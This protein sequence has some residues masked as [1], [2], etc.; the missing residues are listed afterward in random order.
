[1]GKRIEI[2]PHEEIIRKLDEDA[3]L[4]NIL[5]LKSDMT[6]PHTSVFIRLDCGYWDA[7]READLRGAGAP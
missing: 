5:V 4:F 3:K 6:I 1:M 7:A 2:P